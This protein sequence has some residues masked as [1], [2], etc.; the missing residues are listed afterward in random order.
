MATNPIGRQRANGEFPPDEP[1][2]LKS[3]R[4]S[5]FQAVETLSAGQA[6]QGL[7]IHQL[8]SASQTMA[9][10]LANLEGTV[11][12]MQ[13]SGSTPSTMDVGRVP[14]LVMEG[15]P[16]DA[17]AVDVLR[18]PGTSSFSLTW[19]R[20]LFLESAEALCSSPCPL[21]TGN[22]RGESAEAVRQRVLHSPCER[23]QCH[24]GTEA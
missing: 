8:A 1:L 21:W 12:T 5:T 23:L 13:S 16:P 19:P 15:W 2:S 6:K 20:R 22:P 10:R 7:Q 9:A 11:K 17:L 3:I 4:E 18:W 14:A 24:V